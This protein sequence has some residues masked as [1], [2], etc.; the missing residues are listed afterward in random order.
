MHIIEIPEEQIKK[1]SE[2][3]KNSLEKDH[4]WYIHFWNENILIVI[5]GDQIFKF[6]HNDKPARKFAVEHGVNL[7]IPEHQLTFPTD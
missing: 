7:G 6:N 3:L 1:V 4:N 5:F 2:V